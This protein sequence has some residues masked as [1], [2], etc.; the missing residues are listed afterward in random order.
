MSYFP[1]KGSIPPHHLTNALIAAVEAAPGGTARQY[2]SSTGMTPQVVNYMIANVPAL[3][4]RAR[5]GMIVREAM[6]RKPLW[7]NAASPRYSPPKV[8]LPSISAPSLPLP[9][10]SRSPAPVICSDQQVQAA[11]N[12]LLNA[13]SKLSLMNSNPDAK[14]VRV[15]FAEAREIITDMA[16]TA[17]ARGA[18]I[19]T[20]MKKSNS[21]VS[22]LDETLN[23]MIAQRVSAELDRR[24]VGMPLLTA[25]RA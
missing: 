12:R 21:Q 14:C 24:G 15:L 8:A 1:T 22:P 5:L 20:L 16:E 19:R 23:A 10:P 4:K 17:S 9:E 2:A 11:A 6:G 3:L 7:A 13:V 25:Q 18:S